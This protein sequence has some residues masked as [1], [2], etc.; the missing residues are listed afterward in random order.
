MRRFIL[1]LF[2]LVILAA[3]F[4]GR[5]YLMMPMPGSQL[6]E[7]LELAYVLDQ[8]QIAVGVVGA[9][10]SLFAASM[11]V[12]QGRSRWRYVGLLLCIAPAVAVIVGAHLMS[13]ER[14]FR[15]PTQVLFSRGATE[16]IPPETH[17]LGVVNDGVP[18]AYPVRLLA[19]HH[20]LRDDQHGSPLLPTY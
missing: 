15:Q 1:L 16:A 11:I 17:V 9:G 3:P 19:F 20:V 8:V 10:L 18:V 6:T 7:T 4:A 5:T 2:G 13:A 12:R 14:L